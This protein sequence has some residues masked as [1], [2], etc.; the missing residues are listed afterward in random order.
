MGN[1]H[2][3]PLGFYLLET[4]Q[5]ESAEAHVVFDDAKGGFHFGEAACPQALSDLT[6]EVGSGL[7]VELEQA[8]ADEDP[9]VAFWL[10]TLPFERALAAAITCIQ[11][12]IGNITV[13]GYVAGNAWQ[14]SRLAQAGAEGTL[15]I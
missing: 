3:S 8:Q 9:A 6:G 2:Q 13:L 15:A 14:P 7:A 11:A 5:V 4:S 1:T 10:G 12:S